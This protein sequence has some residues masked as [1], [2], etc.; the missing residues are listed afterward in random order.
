MSDLVPDGIDP[1]VLR[2]TLSLPHPQ[3]RIVTY[4]LTARKD[5]EFDNAVV[6]TGEKIA[7]EIGMNRPLLSRTIPQ[8]IKAGWL[9]LA[10]RHG[11]IR[12]Y[13][14]GPRAEERN[15]VVPLRRTA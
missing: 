15:N 6:K 14:L 5:P 12:Y 10:S 9:R 11:N 1:A 13:G 4:Y 2:Q 8:L 7:E 3:M